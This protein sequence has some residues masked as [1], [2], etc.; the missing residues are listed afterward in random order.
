MTQKWRN[1]L[2]W[3]RCVERSGSDSKKE[4]RC[5]D[6]GMHAFS[7]HS[8]SE[9]ERRVFFLCSKVEFLSNRVRPEP[10]AEKSA[11]DTAGFPSLATPLYIEGVVYAN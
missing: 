11:C 5:S 1:R 4:L 7:S 9:K 6:D 10:F 2:N 8:L 3:L